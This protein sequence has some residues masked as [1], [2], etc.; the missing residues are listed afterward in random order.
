MLQD[1]DERV[2]AWGIVPAT[3]VERYARIEKNF[4]RK[5]LECSASMK[6]LESRSKGAM[7]SVVILGHRSNDC[8]RIDEETAILMAGD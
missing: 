2:S 5:A 8:L 4:L 6:R 7:E 1:D 3:D